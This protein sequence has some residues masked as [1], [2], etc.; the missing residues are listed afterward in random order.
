MID[1][2]RFERFDFPLRAVELNL[3]AE[4]DFK[5]PVNAVGTR[6]KDFNT[7]YHELSINAGAAIT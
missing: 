7:N 1:L 5:H 3:L 2:T 4:G 6:E